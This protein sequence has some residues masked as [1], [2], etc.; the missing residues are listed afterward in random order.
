MKIKPLDDYEEYK[1]LQDPPDRD[2]NMSWV[3]YADIEP[4]LFP[5]CS[6]LDIGC[7]AGKLVKELTEREIYSVGIDIGDG[8]KKMWID[9]EK[10]TLAVRSHFICADFIEYDFQP[11]KFD[12]IV[13]SHV[14]EHF[15]DPVKAMQ[16]VWELLIPDGIVYCTFPINDGYGAHY[17]TFESE[18]EIVP[19]FSDLGFYVKIENV[20]K[21]QYLIYTLL[22]KK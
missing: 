9:V 4:Y 19:W 1:L 20:E 12:L 14:L 8:C 22:L 3:S 21:K 18:S 17:F 16:K 15:Y 10:K 13:M 5:N 11:L 6:V 7:K 2:Y